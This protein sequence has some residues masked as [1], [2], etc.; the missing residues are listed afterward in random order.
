VTS[1]I[2][3]QDGAVRVLTLNRP[4]VRNAIDDELQFALLEELERSA[5][6]RSLRGLV[7]TGSGSAFCAGG[8][9]SGMQARFS[10]PAG[11][12][13]AGW[14]RLRRTQRLIA[15]LRDIGLVTVA[16]VNGPAV[17]IGL[18]LAL[19]CDFVVMA[20]SAFVATAFIERGLVPDGGGMYTLPRR[21]GIARAK[22][23]VFSARR[24]PAQEAI[25]LGI[26]DALAADDE[27]VAAA[28][29]VV[30]TY[31]ERSPTAL[32]LAKSILNRASESTLEDVLARSADAQAICYG[33]EEH[34]AS[35][36]AF[37]DAANND[38]AGGHG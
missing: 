15:S 28:I 23:L 22:E 6:D 19:A 25:A 8:D 38:S 2:V 12:S 37:L 7:L 31:A 32:A 17:G 14:Q 11:P 3:K 26:A 5:A 33:T 24:V 35:V 30:A 21:V 36:Q 10:D 27:V 4:Q 18:D 29:G 34:K 16:A 20:E 13:V 1:L 9:I